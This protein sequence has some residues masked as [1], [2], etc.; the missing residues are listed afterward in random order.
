MNE[1]GIVRI[2]ERDFKEFY[3]ALNQASELSGKPVQVIYELWLY[4]VMSGLS[5]NEI[6]DELLNLIDDMESE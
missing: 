1:N 6:L 3:T 2:R 5:Q 4:E